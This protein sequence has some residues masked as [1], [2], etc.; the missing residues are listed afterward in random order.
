MLS[1]VAGKLFNDLETQIISVWLV[2]DNLGRDTKCFADDILRI[3]VVVQDTLDK[4]NVE[5]VI[6][7]R[8]LVGIADEKLHR[9]IFLICISDCDGVT[10]RVK[11]DH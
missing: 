5:A 1:M 10:R 7:E 4:C 8:K 9:A 3:V 11:A 6:R 2:D